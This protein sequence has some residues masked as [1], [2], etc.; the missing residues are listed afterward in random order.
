MSKKPAVLLVDDEPDL[1]ASLVGLLRR[2]FELHTAESGEAALAILDERPIK[3]MMTDQRMP[4]MTGS[5]LIQRACDRTDSTVFVLF[6]G[7]ADIKSVID[8][9]NTGRLFRYVTK[10]WDPDDLIDLLNTAAAEHDRRVADRRLR[11]N[12]EPCLSLGRR[13]CE[14]LRAAGGEQDSIRA[15]QEACERLSADMAQT[16]NTKGK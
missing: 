4:G 10:P 5:E 12:L 9:V 7:Y 1:L 11:E 2:E 13:V 16:R 14:T 6:T 3:V 15:F 8:A